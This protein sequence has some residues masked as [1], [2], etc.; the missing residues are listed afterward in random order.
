MQGRLRQAG[1]SSGRLRVSLKWDTTDDLDL[2]VQTPQGE[3]Y[4]GNRRASGGELDVDRNV[5]HDTI[6]PVENVFWNDVPVG[7]Y[8]VSCNLYS[9]GGDHSRAGSI[10]Y[11]IELDCRQTPVKLDGQRFCGVRHWNQSVSQGKE[12]VFS[13][14]PIQATAVGDGHSSVQPV[15]EALARTQHLSMAFIDSSKISGWEPNNPSWPTF[16]Q[17]VETFDQSATSLHGNDFYYF[18]AENTAGIAQQFQ[19]VATL[20]VAGSAERR[21]IKKAS[22]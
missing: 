16:R 21:V 13:F 11:M 18:E 19:E 5:S 6:E 10:P 1:A 14:S 7:N 20:M 17:N 2:H 3:I 8:T 4:F 22:K 9:R 12:S 15:R